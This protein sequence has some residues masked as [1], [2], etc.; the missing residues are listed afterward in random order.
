MRNRFALWCVENPL[1]VCFF[2]QLSR[3]AH[4]NELRPI[5]SPRN[6]SMKDH[7]G[8]IAGANRSYLA[9]RLNSAGC[10]ERC[11]KS[12]ETVQVHV[13]SASCTTSKK[14]R[15]LC[16]GARRI[17]LDIHR[18]AVILKFGRA[19]LQC[20]YIEVIAIDE[21]KW[22]QIANISGTD[23]KHPCPLNC[24]ILKYEIWPL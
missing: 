15:S 10:A 19:H 24:L 5:R 4:T 12:I 7:D 14:R 9:R 20:I 22:K 1:F 3:A 23:A 16:V 8:N 11:R 6:N 17:L 2:L 13:I 21:N 18:I